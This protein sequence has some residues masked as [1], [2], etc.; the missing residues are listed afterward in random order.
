MISTFLFSLFL[1]ATT[2]ASAGRIALV[3]YNADRYFDQYEIN[4]TNLTNMASAAVAN[5]VNIIVFPEGSLYGYASANRDEQWC[6]QSSGFGCHDVSKIAEAVPAG[7]STLYWE[8]FAKSNGVYV[9]FNLPEKVADARYRNTTVVVGPNG[10]VGKYSKRVLYHTNQAYAE[11]GTDDFI[12]DTPFGKFGLLTCM[13]AAYENKLEDYKSK[14]NSV[15]LMMDWD[16]DPNSSVGAR[17][18]FER[19]STETDLTIY[20]SDMSDWDGS[21]VYRPNQPRER[22]GL[23]P[24]AIGVDGITY[25]DL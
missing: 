23:A 19:R 11:A 24:I 4:Q 3:Q 21:G 6:R 9:L 15:I 16:D 7:A 5:H 25:H 2:Q 22:N 13:D 10:Y 20:A 17:V 12:L 1:A 8:S 18:F 14:V